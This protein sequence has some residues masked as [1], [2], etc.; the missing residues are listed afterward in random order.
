M[1]LLSGSA[2]LYR[3]GARQKAVAISES[4]LIVPQTL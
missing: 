4:R 3:R 1:R 2:F